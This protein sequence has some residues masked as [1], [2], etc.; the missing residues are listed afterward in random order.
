MPLINHEAEAIWQEL[1]QGADLTVGHI[2]EDTNL[3]RTMIVRP[4]PGVVSDADAG[5]Y[6]S[7]EWGEWVRR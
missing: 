5:I 1:K 6:T 3:T 2:C 7:N 4:R